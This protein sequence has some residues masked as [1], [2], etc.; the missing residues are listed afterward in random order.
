MF[1]IPQTHTPS[2]LLTR[3]QFLLYFSKSQPKIV[4][5]FFSKQF[6]R[7]YLPFFSNNSAAA[8]RP[9]CAAIIREVR[10]SS[11]EEDRA[12]LMFAAQEG[13]KASAELLLKNGANINAADNYGDTNLM[14]TIRNDFKTV[15][16]L[17]LNNGAVQ[18][19][20]RNDSES[21]TSAR[22]RRS[23]LPRWRSPL[24]TTIRPRPRGLITQRS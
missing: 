5:P 19:L 6:S 3:N 7:R 21:S 11:S 16:A 1:E 17:L 4:P 23:C 9:N 22:Y 13:R 8:F 24:L 10:S 15:T 20:S 12:A 2:A 18:R 14:L